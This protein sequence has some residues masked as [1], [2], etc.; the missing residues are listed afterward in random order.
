LSNGTISRIGLSL[1]H[2]FGVIGC[3][4]HHAGHPGSYGSGLTG[5]WA[6]E[7]SREGIW[8]ALLSRR[9]YALTGDRVRLE[10]SING[11]PMGSIVP[12]TRE[13][14]ITIRINAGGAIDYVDIVKNNRLI[15]RFSQYEIQERPTAPQIR[16]KLFLEVGW[17]HRSRRTDW[18]IDFGISAG[19]I[20]QVE[21]RFR[22]HLVQSPLDQD[23]GQLD[24]Y[25]SSW[26]QIDGKTVHFHTKTWGNPNPYTNACQG[27]CLEVEASRAAEV[28]LRVNRQNVVVPLDRVLRGAVTGTISEEIESEGWRLHRAPLPHEFQW[29]MIYRDTGMTV[30]SSGE[31]RATAAESQERESDLYYIRARQKNDQW[32]YSSPFKVL[33]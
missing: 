6:R 32:A 33:H 7:L 3:T 29:E 1:G 12:P 14:D 13:R 26:T 31:Q 2:F 18:E 21:P 25:F 16:T 20:L 15:K 22:G 4:D 5:V 19:R 28:V 23:D 9:T 30:S 17:G 27:M 24:T 10:V 11:I 8:E